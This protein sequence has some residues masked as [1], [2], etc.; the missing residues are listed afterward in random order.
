MSPRFD[1]DSYKAAFQG[2]ARQYLFYYKPNFPTGIDGAN[3]EIA[4]FL[5]RATTLPETTTEEIML[6][7]QGF[8]F[9]VA[10]KYTYTD[11]T[12]TFNVD[13]HNK[14][15]KIDHFT[16]TIT[17]FLLYLPFVC[18][19]SDR[20]KTY[21]ILINL[22]LIN[23]YSIYIS[24]CDCENTNGTVSNILKEISFVFNMGFL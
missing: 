16:I 5:V 6:N 4:T 2:G 12:V 7:W 8:D 21:Y 23:I 10:G 11:W 22:L 15:Q 24:C 9:K 18:L 1:I 20:L 3:T 14:I 17:F 19:V 13:V